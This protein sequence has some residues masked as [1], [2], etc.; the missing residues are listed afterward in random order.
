MAKRI[1]HKAGEVFNYLTFNKEVEAV[2]ISNKKIRVANFI[3]KCGNSVD[4]MIKSVRL[5]ITKSCGCYHIEQ[6]KIRKTRLAHNQS[7]KKTRTKEYNTW[8]GMKYRCYNPK[9]NRWSSYG[10]R[11]IIVC[12]R[13]LNSFENF[14]ADMGKK[15]GPEYSI[16]RIDVNGNYEPSNCK[17]STSVEQ[18]NNRRKN[19]IN[20]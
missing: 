1:E 11:G 16:D 5:G 4:I 9:C 12:D 13:W 7:G 15:P 10:G 14:Y 8:S 6:S 2:T 17:W 19:M 3:C 20:G 18:S